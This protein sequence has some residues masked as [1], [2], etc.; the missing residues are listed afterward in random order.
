MAG[1][2]QL[3]RQKNMAIQNATR[4]IPHGV[5]HIVTFEKHGVKGCERAF[6]VLAVAHTLDQA[7]HFGKNTRRVATRHRGLAQAQANFSLRHGVAGQGIHNQ[8]HMLARLDRGQNGGQVLLL[9]RSNADVSAPLVRSMTSRTLDNDGQRIKVSELEVFP[10]I[11]FAA[12]SVFMRMSKDSG[13]SWG[14]WRQKSWSVGEYSKRMNWR[15][16]G[17]ARQWTVE[18]RISDAAEIPLNSE[19]RI[20]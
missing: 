13:H 16:L 6:R 17:Q 20:K 9:S 18:I 12:G 5:M 15:A 19:G 4:G 14:D 8:H 10:R 7:G 2:C 11:G 1:V 3:A